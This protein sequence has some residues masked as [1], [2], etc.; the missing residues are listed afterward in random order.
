MTTATVTD[1]ARMWVG[2]LGCYNG[3]E[4]VGEWMDAA[5]YDPDNPQAS[6]PRI[7]TRPA[8][9]GEGTAIVCSRCGTD[10]ANRWVFDH[11]GF[12]GL[13]VGECTADAA[14]E[15][16]KLLDG[17]DLDELP[18]MVAFCDALGH[19]LAD[20]L[21]DDSDFRDSYNGEWDSR[22]DFA[23]DLAEG[24]GAMPT[25]AA[26]PASYIDWERAA[27]DLFMDYADAPAP[28]GRIYVFRS[29]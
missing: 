21:A 24:I 17:A 16:A 25:D 29:V 3:G 2:C 5:D 19:K 28:G 23:Q 14:H 26:W 22:E 9:Y 13:I 27:R 1:T 10:D 6:I 18:A 12:H 11:E 7:T 15:A 8:M 20:V 4:L